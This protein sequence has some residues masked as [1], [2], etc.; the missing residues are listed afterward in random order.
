MMSFLN[1]FHSNGDQ[2]YR[3]FEEASNNNYKAA[4]LLEKFCKDFKDPHKTSSQI[5]HLEHEGD[6]IAHAI[7]KEI[8]STFVTPLDRED[9]ITLTQSLD[10]VVDLIY[11]SSSTIAIYNVKKPTKAAYNFSKIITASTKSVAEILPK[12][13]HRKTFPQVHKAI[14][15]INRLENEADDLLKTSLTEIFKKPKNPLDVM[16]WRDIYKVM[17][18]VTNKTE[19]IANVLQNLIIKYA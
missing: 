18:A 19:D 8:N 15:E 11:A 4:L 16:R 7:Y 10:D 14:I 6:K 9:I 1:I 12:L 3:W 17:E 2:F 5:H 13:H